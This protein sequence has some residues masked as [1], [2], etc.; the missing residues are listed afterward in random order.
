[1]MRSRHAVSG[2]IGFLCIAGGISLA[3]M[4]QNPQPSAPPPVVVPTFAHD[5]APILYKNC[6]S[7]HRPGE[8]G[9]FSL[10]SYDDA[11][12]HAAQIASATAN[13]VMP[14]WLP[15]PGFGDFANNPRL[16]A[17]EIRL[18]GD[19]VK[20]GAPEGSASEIPPPPNFTE[21]WQLGPPDMIL[22]AQRAFT[23]PAS[24]PDAFYNFIF[25]PSITATRYVRAIE[26]RPGDTNAIH[27]A[28][29]MLDRARSARKQEAEPGA[30]FSG[31]DVKI[32]RSAFDFDTHFLFWKPGNITW[33]E[34]DGLAWRLDPG[35]DLVLNAHMMTMG[36][37]EKVK[38]SIG[39]YFTDQPPTKFP[40]LIRLEHDGALNIPAGDA[41]FVAADNFK[42]P[43][44]VDVLAVYPHAHYL[45]RIVEGFATLP[46]GTRRE[47]IR[48]SHWNLKWQAVYHYS[49][50]VFLPQGTVISMRWHYDNSAANPRNP[51]HPPKRVVSGNQSTDE[52]SHLTFQ[53]LPRGKAD[54]RR[55]IEEALMQHQLEKY[56]DDYQAHLWLGAL[57]LSRLDPNDAVTIFEDAVRL[58]PRQSEG[59]YWLGSALG[60]MGRS[61]EAIEQYRMALALQPDYTNALYNLAKALS[62]SGQFDESYKDFSKVLEVFPEDAQVHVDFGELLMRMGQPVQALGQIEKAL[63]I[64]PKNQAA[65]RDKDLILVRSGSH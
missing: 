52:M 31:M 39:L 42:L 58:E 5:V 48:I 41:D 25:S 4:A 47:L 51:N 65:L 1:M 60:A 64:D 37:P 2:M 24:G 29:V 11:K 63:Q 45:G 33:S 19:W 3:A 40:L 30:G 23:L 16:S 55:E 38:P 35:N 49:E 53:I 34:P 50:P 62:K 13:R 18:I 8:T 27:H 57:M 43:M 14:P 7:C 15:D 59:H 32:V 61:S 20:N 6:S 9:P 56:P 46:N 21:G 12:K 26:I 44:D 22:E 10:L 17:E 54:R 36:M 28:N